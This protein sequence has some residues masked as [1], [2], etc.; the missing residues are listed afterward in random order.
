MD[1]PYYRRLFVFGQSENIP[2]IEIGLTNTLAYIVFQSSPF[3]DDYRYTT[4][5]LEQWAYIKLVRES[6]GLRRFAVNGI[7]LFSLDSYSG[8]LQVFDTNAYTDG[9][10]IGST[11][12][13]IQQGIGPK[14]HVDHFRFER[15]AT[16]IT[17]VPTGP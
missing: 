5:P 10:R 11:A 14:G 16:D 6:N 7:E 9:L 2:Q 12:A 15:F 3:G 4:V 1:S 8:P 17:D 13:E